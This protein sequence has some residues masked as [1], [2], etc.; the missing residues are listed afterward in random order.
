MNATF[1]PRR[2]A[3]V[4]GIGLAVLALCMVARSGHAAEQRVIETSVT[5]DAPREHVWETWTTTQG[6]TTFF[7]PRAH[8]ELRL[9]G[10]YEMYFLNDAPPGRQGSE[11]CRILSYLERQ[12]LSFT[13]NAP[14]QFDQVRGR[15][16]FVVV[17]FADV[18]DH[19]TRVTL[20][21]S[22]WRAGGQ[23]DEVF[24]YFQKA[25]PGVLA[26]LKRR[27]DKGPLWDDS[28][29]QAG[30]NRADQKHWCYFIKPA[31][32]GLLEQQTED[33]QKA[34]R[35]H[36]QHITKLL[37][38]DTLLVAGPCPPK[39]VIH[40]GGENS[41]MLDLPTPGIVIFKAPD[42]HAARNIMQSD[43]AVKAGVFK[44]TLRR[45]HRSFWNGL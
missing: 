8:V 43:P 34:L 12:M 15:K 2:V 42:E 33:E 37:N 41:V 39:P 16:T 6:V 44:A 4:S 7:S 28:E 19:R 35:G 13:W 10:P 22:G 29:R 20:T 18:D 31:R 3:T 38:A 5:V 30:S 32:D 21:H 26:N 40:P 24:A 17:R 9:G 1:C 14:P 36:V 25:W 11:G 27:F 23:W 45:F